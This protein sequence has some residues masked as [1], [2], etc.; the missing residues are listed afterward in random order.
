MNVKSPY[1]IFVYYYY[2]FS[3]KIFASVYIAATFDKTFI[4]KG[5]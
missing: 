5:V 4:S 1:Y 3:I 2:F